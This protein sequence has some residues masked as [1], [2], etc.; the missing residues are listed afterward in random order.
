MELEAAIDDFEDAERRRQLSEPQPGPSRGRATSRTA[1]LSEA[2]RRKSIQQQLDMLA[3]YEAQREASVRME[4]DAELA[5]RLASGLE[6][7]DELERQPPAEPQQVVDPGIASAAMMA[8]LAAQLQRNRMRMIVLPV[9]PAPAPVEGTRTPPVMAVLPMTNRAPALA[10]L[11]QRQPDQQRHQAPPQRMVNP[12]NQHPGPRN[13][14]PFG[15]GLAP[16]QPFHHIALGLRQQQ[17]Q[18]QRDG[19]AEVIDLD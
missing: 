6:L 18:Q 13:T 5:R 7:E 16:G 3:F 8:L 10:R 12:R 9:R 11:Q 1:R 4:K 2:E 15:F 14:T 17:P 19:A